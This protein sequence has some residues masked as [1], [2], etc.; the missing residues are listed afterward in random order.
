MKKLT[1]ILSLFL[2][3]Y[4]STVQAAPTRAGSSSGLFLSY[5]QPQEST[6]GYSDKFYITKV[7]DDATYTVTYVTDDPVIA[8]ALSG[9]RI[10]SFE[11]TATTATITFQ[12][13][14]A[15]SES[16][17]ALYLNLFTSARMQMALNEVGL[18]EAL[19]GAHFSA[20]FG[21]VNSRPV[22]YDEGYV[23]G[24]G[25]NTLSVTSNSSSS[26]TKDDLLWAFLPASALAYI[27]QNTTPAASQ[28]IVR[29]YS[30][31]AFEASLGVRVSSEATSG[32]LFRMPVTYGV[33]ARSVVADFAVV[34][35]TA[36]FAPRTT[37][38][39][40]SKIGL[41]AYVKDCAASSRVTLESKAN[42]SK[43]FKK[44]GRKKLT[45]C[46]ALFTVAPK[47]T[48]TY[49]FKSDGRTYQ[50]RVAIK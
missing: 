33:N 40:K 27:N 45:N 18:K 19:T 15:G 43:K 36:L 2:L 46:A 9:G 41:T 39:P 50:K 11:H 17:E 6:D 14:F 38:K 21:R 49:R 48:T 8:V 31:S 28:V 22:L 25:E 7:S 3:G 44:E 26:E 5:D 42:G 34:S 35:G 29:H 37:L 23:K 47:S 13:A 32:V 30:G 24:E 20:D 16:S 1:L 4:A 10:A 12:S